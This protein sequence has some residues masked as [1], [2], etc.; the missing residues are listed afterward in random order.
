MERESRLNPAAPSPRTGESDRPDRAD[1]AIIRALIESG[2]LANAQRHA[3]GVLDRSPN[4]D[5]AIRIL[6]ATCLLWQGKTA[7][8]VELRNGIEEDS[9]DGENRAEIDVFDARY[10]VQ[11]G[12]WRDCIDRYG[13]VVGRPATNRHAITIGLNVAQA[14]ARLYRPQTARPAL[15]WVMAECRRLGWEE[16][17]ARGR[18]ALALVARMEGQWQQAVTLLQE[19]TSAFAVAELFRDYVKASLDLGLQWLFQGEL[20]GGG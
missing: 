16:G 13:S 2:S 14:Y 20:D 5:P 9:L 7:Q 11:N 10:L 18:L 1:I 12:R 3:R 19:T 4:S 17:E 6:L 8:A 15:N